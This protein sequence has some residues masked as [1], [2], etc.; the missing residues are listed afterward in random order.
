MHHRT[1]MHAE[2]PVRRTSS[3]QAVTIPQ[4]GFGVAC[5][6]LARLETVVPRGC[7]ATRRLRG[8][9]AAS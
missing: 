7:A 1:Y 4:L 8:A 5:L 2:A 3:L 9:A 6:D